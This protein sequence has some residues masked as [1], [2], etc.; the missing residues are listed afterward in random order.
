M[1]GDEE[2]SGD[3]QSLARAALV[4][5]ARG[6]TMRSGSRTAPAIRATP[7][8]RAAAPRRG[9]WRSRDFPRHSSQIFR[10]DVGYGAIYE[11]REFSTASAGSSRARST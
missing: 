9:R 5:A 1:T 2:D 3:P 6:R 7:S 8:P 10:P 4:E 11:R